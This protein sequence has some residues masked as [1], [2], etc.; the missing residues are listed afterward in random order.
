MDRFAKKGRTAGLCLEKNN[1]SNIEATQN[2]AG[3]S[4][5]GP[6]IDEV[7]RHADP[8][9]KPRAFENMPRQHSSNFMLAHE[10][11]RDSSLRQELVQTRESLDVT[12]LDREGQVE[13]L[14]TA[15]KLVMFHVIP[16]GVTTPAGPRRHR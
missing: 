15:E 6:N 8:S 16:Y 9:E 1:T 4:G 13:R 14:E 7:G 12:F 10:A 5:S 2:Q 3:Q 11:S